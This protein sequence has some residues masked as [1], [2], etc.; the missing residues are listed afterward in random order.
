VSGGK[1]DSPQTTVPALPDSLQWVRNSAEYKA[2]TLQSYRQANQRLAVKVSHK[3]PGSWAVVLD[4]DETVLDN[5]QY[6][7]E[8]ALI[9]QGFSLGSWAEWVRRKA[10]PAV[11]GAVRFTNRIHELGG[12]VAIVTNREQAQ[13]ADTAENLD[14]EGILFDVVLCKTDS[15]DKNPRFKMVQDGTTSASLPPVEIEMYVGDQ[16]ADFPALGEDVRFDGEDAFDDFGE[17]LIV[18]PN[19]MYGNWTQNPG[20]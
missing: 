1:A 14:S 13:C 18:I 16:I 7:K 3:Q 20:E 6:Q 19:P 5:S 12:Y 2:L 10:A 8:R 9:G 11:P 4:A 17:L 15:A